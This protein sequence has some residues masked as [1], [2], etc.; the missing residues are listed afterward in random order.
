M[1]IIRNDILDKILTLLMSFDAPLFKDMLD[2]INPSKINMD[3][4]S[5]TLP[6]YEWEDFM[7]KSFKEELLFKKYIVEDSNGNLSITELGKE[8]KRK[9]GY[10]S[11]DKKDNQENTIR[12]KTIESFKYGIWGFWL[13]IIAIIISIIGILLQNNN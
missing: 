9:G 2:K 10:S 1:E 11:I 12:E 13:S 6:E 7:K 8:F 3:F 5:K 4:I